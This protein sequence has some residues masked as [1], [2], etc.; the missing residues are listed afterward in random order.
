MLSVFDTEKKEEE[1][2]MTDREH[3]MEG[4]IRGT[5]RQIDT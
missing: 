1:G 3:Q 4:T 2:I 5:S